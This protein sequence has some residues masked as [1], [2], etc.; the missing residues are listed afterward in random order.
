MRTVDP[1]VKRVK[2]IEPKAVDYR[3]HIERAQA[4][5][6]SVVQSYF[7]DKLVDQFKFDAHFDPETKVMNAMFKPTDDNAP[8]VRVAMMLFNVMHIV[9]NNLV[10]VESGGYFSIITQSETAKDLKTVTAVLSIMSELKKDLDIPTINQFAAILYEIAGEQDL[11]LDKLLKHVKSVGENIELRNAQF[12]LKAKEEGRKPLPPSITDFHEADDLLYHTDALK[13]HV[14]EGSLLNPFHLSSVIQSALSLKDKVNDLYTPNIV[15]SVE[16]ALKSARQIALLMDNLEEKLGLKQDALFHLFKKPLRQLGT[17]LNAFH[18]FVRKE[19]PAVSDESD[20][21]EHMR[22]AR[23]ADCK[24]N[25][26]FLRLTRKKLHSLKTL[27]GSKDDINNA[28]KAIIKL[29]KALCGKA[30]SANCILPI[31]KKLDKKLN[32]LFLMDSSEVQIKMIKQIKGKL[33]KL[34]DIVLE[35]SEL[36]IKDLQTVQSRAES[37]RYGDI[38]VKL[39]DDMANTQLEHI[40]VPKD[41][42]ATVV[43]IANP[44]KGVCDPAELSRVLVDFSPL[45]NAESKTKITCRTELEDMA[46]DW[47]LVP[48]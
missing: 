38:W 39:F 18:N 27:L 9:K 28:P 21:R 19:K 33:L 2:K 29:I 35:D 44:A 30:D 8:I 25:I 17:T 31:D 40:A 23:V 34:T 14:S 43:P 16:L 37:R 6:A 46:D 20:F 32:R 11:Y 36:I 15:V 22:L 7:E 5:L 48:R 4:T 26:K 3:P 45:F 47:V 13:A 10:S 24:N 42:N 12:E 1:R 41:V